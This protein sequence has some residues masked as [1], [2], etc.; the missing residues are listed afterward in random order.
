MIIYIYI[1]IYIYKFQ[2]HLTVCWIKKKVL[3]T[4]LFSKIFNFLYRS[5]LSL[6]NGLMT[7]S[8]RASERNSVVVDSNSTQANFL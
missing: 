6:N 5:F 8:V 3:K 7:Q 4:Q 2:S 1:Y